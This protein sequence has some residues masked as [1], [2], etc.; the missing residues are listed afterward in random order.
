MDNNYGIC[1]LPLIPIRAN[2]SHPSE[3]I[4]QLIFGQMYTITKWE[5]KWLK[6]KVIDDAYEGWIDKNQ[7]QEIDNLLA[8]KTCTQNHYYT[9]N[10][11][12]EVT[13]IANTQNMYLPFGAALHNL[14]NLTF[15]LGNNNYELINGN[16]VLPNAKNFMQ[17]V[18]KT[19]MLFIN[20]P[21]LWGGKTHFGIDCSGFSQQVFKLCGIQL[22]RDAWQQA[23]QGNVV[24]FLE[25]AKLGDLAFFDNN[26][27]KITHVGILLNKHKIIHASAKVKINSIDNYG[28]LADNN[29]GYTHKLR[30]IKRWL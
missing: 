1:H 27:G 10:I 5:E 22:P 23:L 26:E 11:F 28:I 18:E 21:Y 16:A 8:Q 20:A 2:A 24:D 3:M 30:I 29:N 25:T 17:T 14:Q 13:N 4:S 12:S 15:T 9:Q 19:A 7:Y 6:I